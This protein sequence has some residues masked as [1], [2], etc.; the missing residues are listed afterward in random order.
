VPSIAFASEVE[1]GSQQETASEQK[2]GARL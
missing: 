2:T 1:T